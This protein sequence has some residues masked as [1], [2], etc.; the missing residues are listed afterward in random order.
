MKRCWGEWGGKLVI[1]HMHLHP[2]FMIY[3]DDKISKL[4]NLKNVPKLFELD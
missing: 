3:E 2:D 4:K 1:V